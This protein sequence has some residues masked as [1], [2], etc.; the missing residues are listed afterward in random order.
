[1]C[2]ICGIVERDRPIDEATLEAMCATMVHRGPDE[3]GVRLD[4]SGPFR[5][6]LGHRRLSI[7]DLS[8]GTQP[9][10]NEDG[11][12]WTIVNGEIYNY[13]ELARELEAKGHR[14]RTRSDSEVLVHLWEEHG[15]DLLS[16]LVGM[17]AFALWDSKNAR[18]LLARDRLGK[19][20]L[21]YRADG[22]SLAFASRLE[23]L[24]VA[25][26][27]SR[28]IDPVALDRYLVLQYVPSP[29]TILAGVSKIPPAHYLL[30]DRGKVTVERY[31]W[32]RPAADAPRT[33]EEACE[34]LRALLTESVRLRMISDV[35]LGAFLSGGIDSSVLVGI[36]AGLSSQP[37][38][39]FSI[40]FDVPEWDE[41][42]YA[43]LVAERHKTEHH[44]LVV[45]PDARA[46]FPDLVRHY[47]EP[48][49][50]SSAI[51]TWYVSKLAREH[52]TVAL[53]GD[54]GDELFAGYDRYK[55]VALGGLL[56]AILP[57]PV[58][59]ALEQVAG[60]FHRDGTR[61]TPAYRA[62]KFF[63]G[64][65]E[66]PLSR[67]IEWISYF[68]RRERRGLYRPE[69][70]EILPPNPPHDY[71]REALAP[72]A[73]RRLLASILLL[74][75]LTYLP[76]ALLTKVDVASMAHSLEVRTP[77]LDHRVVEAALAMPTSWK[78]RGW[79]EKYVLKRAFADLLPPVVR[80]RAK[81]GFAVPLGAWFRG[82]LS[83]LVGD[84][85]LSRNA[86][87]REFFRPAAL[88]RLVREHRTGARSHEYK[89]WSILFLEMWCQVFL[90]NPAMRPS[91]VRRPERATP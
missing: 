20:P 68:P 61:R 56:G 76:E 23:T 9:I 69:W 52:V 26:G 85:L 22:D 51:P 42:H 33:I 25:D 15:P 59:R 67:Y 5:I 4:A 29:R 32:P 88:E 11:T 79:K 39:T 18:L 8:T 60:A 47:A 82:E 44:E 57:P 40:G 43:R 80:T 41:R 55:G 48:F 38:R 87:V 71:F 83:G 64:L 75:T 84:L 30:Y 17:F 66:P 14:F 63:R 45:S 72:H 24:L 46:I 65:A 77:F 91:A 7:I 50:D 28:E 21:F 62:A 6:G 74:D 1:M 81:M 27:G 73:D 10:G 58:A 89:L 36:M 90:R 49:A 70:A 78:L 2:G 34:R 37:V 3:G 12:V 13:Q 31:W 86:R 54:G 19:K 35:P 53:S 16:H